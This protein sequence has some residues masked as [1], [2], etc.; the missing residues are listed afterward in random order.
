MLIRH[1]IFVA[2]ALAMLAALAFLIMW[3]APMLEPVAPAAVDAPQSGIERLR[4]GYNMPEG[5]V[6]HEAAV[7][8]AAEL[9]ASSAGRLQVELFP[10]QQLGNDHQMLEMARRGE[11]DLLLTPTAKL[12]VALPQMQ[13]PDLPFYFPA[14]DDLYD[15]LDGEPGQMLLNSMRQIGLVGV[16]FWGNG[17]KQFTSDRPLLEPDDFSGNRYRIMKSRLLQTQFQLLGAEAIP[18][19]FHQVRQALADGVVDGQ[20][21]PIAAIHAMGIH[22]VQS[23]LTLSSHA[24]LAYALSIS[25][26]RFQQL[27]GALQRLIIDKAR[28]ITPWMRAETERRE[29]QLLAEMEAGGMQIH[30]LSAEQRARFRAALRPLV[31][32]FESTIGAD[33][34]ALSDQWLYQRYPQPE[35]PLVA[36]D[37]DLSPAGDGSG[38]ELKRG[39]ELALDAFSQEQGVT[40][41]MLMLVSDN[42]GQPGRAQRNLQLLAGAANWIGTV[43]GG[44]TDSL[45]AQLEIQGPAM[46]V[47]RA[48]ELGL[49]PKPV[50]P[51]LFGVSQDNSTLA[52]FLAS[53]LGDQRL[54]LIVE[55]S[56]W[57]Q[58]FEHRLAAMMHREGTHLSG[59]VTIELG[60]QQP[61]HEALKRLIANSDRQLLAVR[62]RERLA[63]VAAL[64]KIAPHARLVS[65]FE[66]L[67]ATRLDVT[68]VRVAPDSP[69]LAAL[70]RRYRA[71]YGDP[72]H[73]PSLLAQ[74]YDATWLLATA[75]KQADENGPMTA[76]TVT[77]QLEQLPAVRGL[78][79]DYT[80][81]FGPDR[82]LA[83]DGTEFRLSAGGCT[84]STGTMP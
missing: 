80:P 76:E 18:I 33:L 31:A 39:V 75:V 27:P 11:L 49:L 26:Q 84:L 46:L 54:G 38:L 15:L 35:R 9:E 41:R 29:A 60:G 52:R 82:H 43:A 64:E 6:M 79:R 65:L 73:Y 42:R 16:T 37:V 78:I 83:L 5:S 62:S 58:D 56:P 8:L 32:R 17:F 70:E 48:G 4:F 14:S 45:Q 12:S 40:P 67:P 28:E 71:R 50:L 81:A 34:L 36:V 19:D 66:G 51:R 74:A 23:D 24:Y 68:C 63:L 69:A 30:L 3:P 61:D 53:R 13:Y 77:E 25:E 59:T 1:L 47:P 7:R 55:S 10:N 44:N 22:E 21:N 2:A 20:E 57:G 72:V